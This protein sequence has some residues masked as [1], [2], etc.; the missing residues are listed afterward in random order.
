MRLSKIKLAGFKS[1]VD[2]TTIQLPSSLIGVVGP[3]GCGKS[4]VIDAV[5]W[6]M[7]ES[8][9]K[10]LRG[11]SMEDVI[12]NGS[13]AR[14]PVGQASVELIFDNS[15]GT[16]GGQ[17]A[18]Y[19]EIS[20]KRQV[21]RD[22]QS[23][24]YLNSS[25]CRRRDITDIFLGTGLGPRS[26]AIIEQGMISRLIE[27]KPEELRVYL[28]EAAGISK[29]KERR[30]E[31]ENRIKHT[32]ENLEILNVSREEVEKQLEHL[33]R[34][35][36]AAER[37]KEYK[38][39]ERK[40]KAELLVL[41]WRALDTEF[42]ARQ[43]QLSELET[44]L[45]GIIAEQRNAESKIEKD[46]ERLVEVNEAFN[47]VQGKYYSV[48]AD[49]SRVEQSI[50][51]NRETAEK[52]KQELGKVD[53]S[54]KEAQ[55]HIN[56][57]RQ[58]LEELSAAIASDEPAYAA[59]LKDQQ[60]SQSFLSESEQAMSEWQAHWED[61]TR[62]AN[63]PAREAEVQQS[64]I[65]QIEKHQTQS[66][67]RLDKLLAESQQLNT[68]QVDAAIATAS[69]EEQKAGKQE[70]AHQQ[71]VDAVNISVRELRATVE[72]SRAQLNETTTELQ[73]IGGRLASVEALQ[74]AALGKADSSS[75]DWLQRHS[76][77][78]LPRLAE[79]LAVESGW[80][81]AVETALGYY[82]EAVCVDTDPDYQG[83]LQDF[84]QGDVTLVRANGASAAT[85][86]PAGASLLDKVK[87]PVALASVL[88]K[89]RI[90]YDLQ[91]ALAIKSS[92]TVEESVITPQ[93]EWFGPN[94]ARISHRSE[95]E[96]GVIAR[97]QEIKK[98]Q[99][100]QQSLRTSVTNLE[101]ERSR[102]SEELQQQEQAREE[103]LKA[104]NETH[105]LRAQALGR[106]QQQRA[107]K[108]QMLEQ[109]QR[110]ERES[111]ELRAQLAS[112]EQ[113]I[114]SAKQL[115]ADAQS[116]VQRLEGERSQLIER[117]ENLRD[118]LDTARKKTHADRDAGHEI[119]MRMQ[120]MRSAHEA[121]QQNLKRVERQLEQ[122][123]ERRDELQD[124]LKESEA[125]RQQ[126]QD[127]LDALLQKR[128]GVEKEL[129]EARKAVEEIETTLRKGEEL[130][131]LAETRVNE[132]RSNLERQ[133]LAW[134]EMKVR[135]QTLEEQL[136]ETGFERASLLE[137]LPQDAKI[138]KWS[139]EVE[140]MARKI[141]RLGPINLAAIDEYQEQLQRKEYLDRQFADV[142]EAL[143][144]LEA[145]IEKIDKE[146]RER[147]KVTFEQVSTR[148]KELF[149]RLFGGGQAHLELTGD[150]LLN[151]GVSVMARP[152][153]K[154]ISNI[155]LLSGGEKA[156]TAVALVFAFFELNPAP[157][158]MLDEVDAPLDDAN[159]GRFCEMVKEMSEQVQFIFITHNKATMELSS[160][161]MGVTMQEPGVSRLVAVDVHEAAKLANG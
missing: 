121:T 147:F 98:L 81:Q 157:F 59:R 135:R 28:E 8:S 27:A 17:Y 2:P 91:E 122:L 82:L 125:P 16:L 10:H 39:E 67:Q 119:A 47:K 12:F 139:G 4:N 75:S 20:V 129:A 74:Q 78:G 137:G 111:G 56:Q 41:R 87:A 79:Q 144:T 149:P 15:D 102:S 120:S 19:N 23:Q 83:L 18:Q 151:T 104:L 51:H 153:G 99:A 150:D 127:E 57:D 24:Y 9:A 65:A 134:Q 86:S 31:T 105:R 50:Q 90:A 36:R 49:I 62:R 142:N 94:W 146:T 29:Y 21:S 30:R 152:P 72:N 161:L 131:H 101:T 160:H 45:E 156:L 52:Y 84:V 77:D 42:Q 85:T 32:R 106:V 43:K 117:K 92:L 76:L 107:R 5:R 40:L 38:E 34:Q 97:E 3:N 123:R 133:R 108:E 136:A 44:T 89:V 64:R 159:V 37:Y 48:G 71:G 55:T 93:G 128:V 126:Q 22:G 6:V 54:W 69:E 95:D 80:E 60:E 115:Y 53:V 70:V 112:G 109:M 114:T 140:N 66:K 158:C 130:R 116:N 13:S 61:F 26:Y 148:L 63:E 110:L 35:S 100:Q 145:A 25:R 73:T 103:G 68:A 113:D 118:S 138:E 7:G 58:K 33:K 155:H 124:A 14:K 11:D 1:F 46:R 96:T 143:T 88:G 154:R 141:Q 132:A